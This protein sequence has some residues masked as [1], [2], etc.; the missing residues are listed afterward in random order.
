MFVETAEYRVRRCAPS[1][2][3]VLPP[4]L[5]GRVGAL[6]RVR[7]VGRPLPNPPP[8][9]RRGDARLQICAGRL[10]MPATNSQRREE[11]MLNRRTVS[12]MLAGAVAAPRFA[13][14]QN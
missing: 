11:D 13:F 5:Q 14:A 10:T 1:T 4:R 3:P 6:T 7:T 8:Q 12:A 9:A 2:V